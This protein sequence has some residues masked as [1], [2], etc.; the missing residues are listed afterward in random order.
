MRE[1]I[2]LGGILFVIT[3][4][5]ALALGVVNSLT[6]DKIAQ[7]TQN[8]QS[9]AGKGVIDGTV[10]GGA[11]VSYTTSGNTSVDKITEH[12][13]A[14]GDKA[15][16]VSCKPNGYD[17]AISMTVGLDNNLNVTGVAIIAMRETPGLGARAKE[18]LFYEQFIGKKAGVS[19]TKGTPSDNQIQAISGA[20][21][22]SRAVTKGVNDAIS[23]VQAIAK[24]QPTNTVSTN[25]PI[26]TPTT[27][28]TENPTQKATTS[29]TTTP[30]TPTATVA[31]KPVATSTQAPT[32]TPNVQI[33]TG[34][35]SYTPSGNTS[36][37][38]ISKTVLANGQTSYSVSCKPMGYED[39]ISMVVGLDSNLNV[40]GVK[41]T[42]INDTPGRGSKAQDSSFLSQFTGKKAGV[43]VTRGAA[44][45]N[46]IQAIS[47]ATITSRAV[48]QGV[49]DAIT[50]AKAIAGGGN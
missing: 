4:T 50:E 11:E 7:N 37:S 5:V 22:T 18:P 48:A 26:T 19:V 16:S 45:G 46:Q 8:A 42:S 38:K 31:P 34:T 40:T 44:S 43:S 41:I 20:T 17:G 49:N 3:L 30:T 14:N 47:G 39:V 36:V 23:E 9:E 32:P 12:K 21:I 6:K 2:K 28:P 27:A 15:Y 25:E 33:K 13:L 29:P 1:Y 24:T 35:T 10:Q